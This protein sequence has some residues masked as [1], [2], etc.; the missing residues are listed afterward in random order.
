[1]YTIIFKPLST[2]Q[3]LSHY[4]SSRSFIKETIV[5]E[6]NLPQREWQYFYDTIIYLIVLTNL[7]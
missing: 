5:L 1:M 3:Q 6:T 4:V 2:Y 7:Y